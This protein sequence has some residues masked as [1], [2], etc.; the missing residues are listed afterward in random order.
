MRRGL[1]A[2]G[3]DI[4]DL[5]E[6]Q[7]LGKSCDSRFL[8]RVFSAEERGRIAAASCPDTLLWA[9]WAAKEAAYKCVSR[10]DPRVVSI[11]R[12]YPVI[13]DPQEDRQG[14]DADG[15]ASYEGHVLTP[16]GDVAL[17]IRATDQ[18]VHALA[19]PSGA[20]LLGIVQGVTGVDGDG[21]DQA[22]RASAVVRRLLA[23]EIARRLG[24][25]APDLTI[26]PAGSGAPGVFLRGRPLA[27]GISLSHDGRFAAFA[28]DGDSLTRQAA[29]LSDQPP[30][31]VVVGKDLPEDQ[32]QDHR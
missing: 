5:K 1:P 13:L 9:L 31:R 25:S 18:Y 7:S 19:A 10:G 3:N 24:C 11:P 12:R 6:P 2:V 29:F 26:S 21:A 32:Q 16:R 30:H 27:V 15:C 14:K 23:R 20:A 8:E 22:G 4:V 17:R 28:L